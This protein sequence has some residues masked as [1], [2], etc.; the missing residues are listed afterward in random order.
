MS[1]VNYLQ[2]RKIY[3]GYI[4][5][6][7][8]TKLDCWEILRYKCY[9][10]ILRSEVPVVENIK[11]EQGCREIFEMELGKCCGEILR[12]NKC[13]ETLSGN[14]VGQDNRIAYLFIRKLLGNY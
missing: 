4:V 8:Q 12:S 2:K 1:L 11:I 6:D 9:W 14:V 3:Y 7:K 5:L 13:W 10:E